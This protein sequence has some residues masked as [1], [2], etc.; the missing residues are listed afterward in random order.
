MFGKVLKISSNDLYGNVDDRVVRL[1]AC[2]KHIKYNNNYVIF[3][4]EG[5]T[6]K[7]YFGSV[8]M[9]KNSLVIFS[10]KD[11]IKDYIMS[12]ID[13]YINSKLN[14]FKLIDIKDIDKVELVSSNDI[15]YDNLLTLDE[16]SIP[17]AVVKEE[18]KVKENKHTFLY[19]LVVF[20]VLLAIGLT[21]VYFN[22]EWFIVK[23]NVLECVNNRLY[24]E[25]LELYY[26]INENV[27]FDTDN[28]VSKIDVIRTYTFLEVD[29]YFEFKNNNSQ[30]NYFNYDGEYK[31][32]DNELKIKIFYEETSVIDDYDEMFTYLKRKGFSCV[33]KEYEK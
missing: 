20:L 19:L 22:P 2:F 4:F 9:K 8:H 23:Y 14:E 6:K 26:D 5:D 15:D 25:E 21:V 13:E 28:K 3:S 1:Y 7:L 33:E 16:L 31:Y 24:D 11:N 12:F 27:I 17:K 10:V 29:D 18:I 32:I 30:D